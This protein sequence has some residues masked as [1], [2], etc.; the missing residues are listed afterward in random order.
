MTQ[1]TGP[2]QSLPRRFSAL[3]KEY[4]QKSLSVEEMAPNPIVQCEQWIAEAAERGMIE[5]NAMALATVSAEGK[6]AVRTVLL[7]ELNERGLIFFSNY[8]SR[9]G[10]EIAANPDVALLFVWPE[11]ERQIRI[12]GTVTRVTPGE[13]DEYFSSRPRGAQLSAHA[14]KQSAPIDRRETLEARMIELEA[15]FAGG[16]ISR[17][18]SW[19]GY[20]VSPKYFEFWQ[21]RLNRLHDRIVYVSTPQGWQLQRLQ[22]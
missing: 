10:R 5:P 21:G 19:G 6:P 4:A 9:K 20:R 13:S 18:A 22:P 2:S 15:G 14:S 12:E 8:E 7:K 3:R 17:P 16:A 1:D 11:L